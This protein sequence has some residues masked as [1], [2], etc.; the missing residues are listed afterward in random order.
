M[1]RKDV[2][3]CILHIRDG[4]PKKDPKGLQVINVYSIIGAIPRQYI[5][6]IDGIK[7]Y[8]DGMFADETLII[9]RDC[10]EYKRVILNAGGTP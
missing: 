9:H 3:K 6:W 5:K 8:D 7:Y 10:Y 2:K 1:K 4:N